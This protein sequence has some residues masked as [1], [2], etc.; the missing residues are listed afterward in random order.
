MVSMSSPFLRRKVISASDTQPS[1]CR[2]LASHCL[3]SGVSTPSS[4]EVLPMISERLNPE[5]S[6]N[7]A[8][9]S[10]YRPLSRS[11][12]DMGAGASWKARDAFSWFSR[13]ASSVRLRAVTSVKTPC[14]RVPPSA[15]RV[16]IERPSSHTS[17]F[18]GCC[19]RN[20]SCQS[21]RERADSSTL[22]RTRALSSGWVMLQAEQYGT[23]PVGGSRARI[24]V[25]GSRRQFQGRRKGAG[26]LARNGHRFSH[27]HG[28]D[29]THV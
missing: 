25:P 9:T 15:S 1:A 14:Q 17:P 19:T 29:E 12:I 5:I 27:R 18:A 26:Y 7:L 22:Q 20:S 4:M 24:A 11:I 13:T 21:E 23:E 2:T 3:V 16:G 8:F 6:A 28:R 10:I